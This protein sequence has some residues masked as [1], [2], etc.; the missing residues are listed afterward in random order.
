MNSIYRRPQPKK[1][2][3]QEQALAFGKRLLLALFL[4]FGTAGVFHL[5]RNGQAPII[6]GII[7]GFQRLVATASQPTPAT[8]Q[9]GA[10]PGAN[11]T[12]P[13]VNSSQPQPAAR[14]PS[15]STLPPS[16]PSAFTSWSRQDFGDFSLETPFAMN[17][18]ASTNQGLNAYQVRQI[19]HFN[20]WSGKAT[21]DFQVGAIYL[22]ID[23]THTLSLEDGVKGVVRYFAKRAGDADPLFRK[24]DLFVNGLPARRISYMR[25]FNGTNQHMEGLVVQ[26]SRKIM[27]VVTTFAGDARFADAQR[28]LSSMD[29]RAR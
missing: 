10:V 4:A 16:Q 28:V 6:D 22:E 2:R 13:G 17:Q 9:S 12:Q 14:L 11:S 7:Q 25:M 18:E 19:V 20:V 21:N 29:V 5:Y 8:T 24:A 15:P 3:F 26:A 1:P 23:G 27:G